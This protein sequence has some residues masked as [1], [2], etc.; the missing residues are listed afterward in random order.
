KMRVMVDADLKRAKGMDPA[1]IGVTTKQGQTYIEQAGNAADGSEKSPPFN[2]Y[3]R[4]FRD[5]TAY[6]I[7]PL[8]DKQVDEVIACINRLE[9]LDDIRELI[10]LLS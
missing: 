9:Q 8:S 7:K 1:K 4:K 3:E 5:C 6:S 10:K 2:A